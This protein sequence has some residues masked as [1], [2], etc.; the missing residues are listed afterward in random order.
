M[1][2]KVKKIAIVIPV[3]NEEEIIHTVV[4]DIKDKLS[5]I[6]Y[7]IIILNDGSTD[8]TEK[9][10]KIYENDKNILIINKH[11]EGHGKT[12]IRGYEQTLKM[13]F[14]YIVQIDSDDQIPIEELYKLIEFSGSFDLV[15]GF[16]YKRNDPFIRILITNILKYII[17][18]RHGV[19][20]E[21]SNIPLRIMSKL[22]LLDNIDKVKNSFIP[23]VLLSILASKKNNFKQVKTIHKS[24]NTGIVSIRK[25]NLLI[26]C[27][28]SLLEVIKFKTN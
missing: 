28:R 6:D 8:N 23:N 16:R 13:D 21:D 12:L 5:N 1:S 9:K 26:L 3:Y 25:L 18:I 2:F 24:R 19:F 27:I 17:F 11:N 14:D 7:K 4:E 20:I 10:L 22:F 15:C